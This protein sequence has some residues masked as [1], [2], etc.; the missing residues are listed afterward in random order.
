M[1]FNLRDISVTAPLTLSGPVSVQGTLSGSDA[2]RGKALFS[3]DGK[4]TSF[5]IKFAKAFA[6]EPFVTISTNQFARARLAQVAAD[7]VTV[8]F[9]QPPAAGKDNVVVYWMTQM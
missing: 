8:E 2:T 5:T 3:G 4:L 1:Q 6:S 9:E 7:H